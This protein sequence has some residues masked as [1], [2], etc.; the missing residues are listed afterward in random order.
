MIR[1]AEYKRHAK[2]CREQAKRI[3]WPEDKDAL[4]RVG[5]SGN[6]LELDP[7]LSPRAN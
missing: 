4:E 6:E 2:E 3:L 7:E 5:R 1:A